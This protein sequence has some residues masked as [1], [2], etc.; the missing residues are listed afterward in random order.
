MAEKTDNQAFVAIPFIFRLSDTMRVI[1][2]GEAPVRLDHASFRFVAGPPSRY[3]R[4]GN[5]WMLERDIAGGGPLINVGVHMVDLFRT[6]SG[7][8][9][10]LDGAQEAIASANRERKLSLLARSAGE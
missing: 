5:P 10:L 7:F 1:Q 9:D 6:L 8:D 2:G 4:A 3:R